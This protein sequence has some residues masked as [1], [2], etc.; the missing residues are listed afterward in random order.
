MR[1]LVP[2]EN[3]YQYSNS[4]CQILVSML[5]V[6]VGMQQHFLLQS[7]PLDMCMMWLKMKDIISLF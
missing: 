4:M 2:R 3:L 6:D 5:G 7:T 1:K